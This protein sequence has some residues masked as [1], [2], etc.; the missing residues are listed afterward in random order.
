MQEISRQLVLFGDFSSMNF[1]QISDAFKGPINQ[2]NLTISAIQDEIESINQVQITLP[3]NPPIRPM[4]ENKNFGIRVLFLSKKIRIIGES[5]LLNNSVDVFEKLCKSIIEALCA[6]SIEIFR[7]GVNGSGVVLNSEKIKNVYNY[8]FNAN[9]FSSD[10]TNDWSFKTNKRTKFVLD[11]NNTLVVN[12]IVS[13]ITGL[14]NNLYA[15][16][17]NYDFNNVPGKDL[18]FSKDDLLRFIRDG[19][20][21]REKVLRL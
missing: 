12:N 1:Q 2:F 10:N 9:E 11:S 8:F 5:G 13:A 17:L 14:F 3:A 19:Y 16:Q 6:L 18:V 21:Y 15:L 4:F 7:V 20:K